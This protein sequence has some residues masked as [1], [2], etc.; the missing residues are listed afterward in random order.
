MKYKFQRTALALTSLFSL[1]LSQFAEYFI[2]VTPHLIF[3]RGPPKVYT[4]MT[5][6]LSISA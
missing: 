3:Y 6:N 5:N 4:P 1:S 2:I